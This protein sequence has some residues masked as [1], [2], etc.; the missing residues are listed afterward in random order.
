[1][2]I[3]LNVQV[4]PWFFFKLK[5]QGN[6]SLFAV[7]KNVAPGLAFFVFISIT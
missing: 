7:A 5:T 4:M 1:M 2:N 3:S 6:S